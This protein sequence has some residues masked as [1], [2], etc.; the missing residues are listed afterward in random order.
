MYRCWPRLTNLE[1]WDYPHERRYVPGQ[2][3]PDLEGFEV[4]STRR[5]FKSGSALAIWKL[6]GV[7]AR[8]RL[9]AVELL[10]VDRLLPFDSASDWV[11]LA[12]KI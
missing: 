12:R 2:L 10:W 8:L 7:L 3:E 1:C 4:V 5:L 6:N 9:P 11:F